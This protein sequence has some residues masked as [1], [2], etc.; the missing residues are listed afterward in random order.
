MRKLFPACLKNSI[1]KFFTKIQIHKKKKNKTYHCSEKY[2]G[3]SGAGI[4]LSRL[5]DSPSIDR[6]SPI[7]KGL[8]DSE[9]VSSSLLF[10]RLTIPLPYPNLLFQNLILVIIFD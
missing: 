7:L 10:V 1:I 6:S 3:S 4:G 8:G 5:E 9:C 2:G